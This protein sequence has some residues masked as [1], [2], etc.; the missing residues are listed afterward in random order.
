MGDPG[1]RPILN[2]EQTGAPFERWRG[3]KGHFY[4]PQIV[5][6]KKGAF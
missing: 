3:K 2:Q 5:I 6:V 4:F 1:S